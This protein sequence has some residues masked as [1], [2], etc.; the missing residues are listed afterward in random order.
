MHL[1]VDTRHKATYGLLSRSMIADLVNERLSKESLETYCLYMH[2]AIINSFPAAV[3]PARDLT[4]V[5]LQWITL[6]DPSL[7]T[8]EKAALYEQLYRERGKYVMWIDDQVRAQ[9]KSLA[10][11]EVWAS[12]C[13][14]YLRQ[15]ATLAG[16]LQLI[17]IFKDS[18]PLTFGDT[19][20][21][22]YLIDRRIR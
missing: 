19:Y 10:G 13:Q 5:I 21:A 12:H 17:M 11:Y 18:V 8:P 1:P 6:Q 9:G 15:N 4:S 20:A 2:W 7:A 3:L 16:C 22:I 14:A